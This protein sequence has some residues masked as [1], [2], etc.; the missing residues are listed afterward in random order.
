MPLNSR[1]KYTYRIIFNGEFLKA[2]NIFTDEKKGKLIGG[3]IETHGRVRAAVIGNR[4]E[5]KTLINVKGF[6]LI[7]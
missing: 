2:K 3:V 5:R 4:M 1:G 6:N 7:F